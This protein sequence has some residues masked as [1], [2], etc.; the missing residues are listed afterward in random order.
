VEGD[1]IFFEA[2]SA[3]PW[4]ERPFKEMYGHHRDEINKIV[5]SLQESINRFG[6]TQNKHL[7]SI[8]KSNNELIIL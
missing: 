1:E 8:S 4:D 6:F 5:S 3:L 7:N 2:A